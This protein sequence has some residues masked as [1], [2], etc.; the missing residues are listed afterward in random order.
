LKKNSFINIFS[1]LPEKKCHQFIKNNLRAPSSHLVSTWGKKLKL[2][3]EEIKTINSKLL[4][5][6]QLGKKFIEKIFLSPKI[7]NTV[8]VQTQA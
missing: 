2:T 5:R 1:I 6:H 3:D 4:I 8:Q 7:K